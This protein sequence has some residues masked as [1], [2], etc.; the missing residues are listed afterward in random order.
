MKVFWINKTIGLGFGAIDGVILTNEKEDTKRT[1]S[2]LI[3]SATS[4]N[5]TPTKMYIF[6]CFR[7]LIAKDK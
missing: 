1:C 6:F 4:N 2:A 5:P 3:G 7:I